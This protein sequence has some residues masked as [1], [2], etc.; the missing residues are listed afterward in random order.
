MEQIYAAH[1][2]ED[3]TK[4]QTVEE[5]NRN[6][7]VMASRFASVFGYSD[8]AYR[9]GLVHDIG[10]TSK[11]FQ[12]R[13]LDGGPKVDHATA[14]AVVLGKSG[15]HIGAMCVAG[16]HSGLMDFGSVNTSVPHDGTFCGRIKS[17]IPEYVESD[18]VLPE[19]HTPIYGRGDKAFGSA[20]LI[21][22]L[23]SC[24]V[25]AD[26]L[27]TEI[28][29]RG[30]CRD[31]QYDSVQALLDKFCA[32]VKPWLDKQG[33]S[34]L[35]G[36]RNEILQNCMQQGRQVPSGLYTLT[37]PTGG[38][39][40][41]ASLGF[42]LKHVVQTG[43]DRI[44][45]VVPYTS[46]IEQ[47]A[48]VFRKI[49]GF[50]NVLEHHA[51]YDGYKGE[52][53]EEFAKEQLASENWDA[54]VIVTTAVR[55]FEALY[56][57]KSSRL[58]RLHNIANSVVIFDEAQMF[59][60][61]HLTPC[62]RGIE[63]LVKNYHVTAVLCT[64]TCP[65]LD[66][67][68]SIPITE[69]QPDKFE[70]YDLLRRVTIDVSLE[71]RSTE[72]LAEMMTG[73]EQ[74]LCIVNTR[75][76]AKDVYDMLPTGGRYHLSTLMYPTHRRS[77]LDKIR[78]RLRDGLPVRL[79]STSLVEAGVDV[80]FPFVMR[81][82]TGLDSILQAAGRCNREGKRLA[83]DSRVYV[84]KRG[85]QKPPAVLSKNIGAFNAVNNRSDSVDDIPAISDY[86]NEL[87]RLA[88]QGGMDRDCVVCAFTNP[89]EYRMPKGHADDYSGMLPFATVSERFHFIHGD[90]RTVY[91]QNKDSKSMLDAVR[92]GYASRDTYRKLGQYAVSLMRLQFDN[93]VRCGFIE[94]IDESSGTL[95][96][97]N[98]YSMETGLKLDSDIG[99]GL[100]V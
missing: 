44:I 23:Y 20:F 2:S 7:A 38:G 79:V 88:G 66:T 86:F 68:F 18:A 77:V 33:L 96:Q 53:S 12:H 47:N 98:L 93:Y 89:G 28:F 52:T 40:T 32:Y 4:I 55:F 78:V 14:G 45:Y 37:V 36:K 39:K 76:A 46:I 15:D 84:F 80:D 3:G 54:P 95:V 85:G 6:V 56:G 65:A 30:E 97:E 19:T 26:F 41:T 8:E 69:L 63:E 22:M 87:Y 67:K 17:E 74:V 42:A 72:E 58:R 64:A 60:V 61:E 16:H 13:I 82:I 62:V 71:E 100:F 1:I 9:I 90:T 59:P 27:D 81:E 73:Y 21:R 57:H 49:L 43:K 35:D 75:Q 50:D 48:A 10:K 99:E 25:D 92:F 34:L 83:A 70:L 29:M 11:E 94:R 5:H 24:L 51:S 31:Y 91:I